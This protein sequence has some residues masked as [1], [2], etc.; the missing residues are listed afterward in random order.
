MV[1]EPFIAIV[2]KGK[3]EY[4]PKLVESYKDGDRLMI[5]P[6]EVYD[7]LIDDR[8]NTQLK[9]DKIEEVLESK[10]SYLQDINGDEDKKD[11]LYRIREILENPT[12]IV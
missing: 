11:K 4:G 2:N 8:A 9:L 5:A 10:N 3:I 6:K 1:G 7:R 12:R